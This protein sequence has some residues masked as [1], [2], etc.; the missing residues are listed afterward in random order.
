MI[1]NFNKEKYLGDLFD[2]IFNQTYSNWECIIVDDHSTDNSWEILETYSQ[3]DS[4]IK[5]F[6]RPKFRKKG[7]S[8]ARNYAI[9]LAK[10]EYVALL[11][12]DDTWGPNRLKLAI[13]FLSSQNIAAIFSGAI[14][15]RQNSTEKLSS[16]DINNAESIFD[17]I[18]SDDVFCP[19]PSLILQNTLARNVMFDEGLKRHEDFDFFIRVHAISPWKYFE[20]YDVRINWT[21]ED[22]KVINFKECIPFYEKHWQKSR[23]DKI[24]HKYIIRITSSS[25]RGNYKYN[26]AYYFKKVLENEGY[27]FSFKQYILFYM[28]FLF[29]LFSK[30]KWFFL[31]FFSTSE[32]S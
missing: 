10:G 9:E 16:R 7:V 25:V 26:L 18:F 22:L 3:K 15:L 17:F 13:E 8:T 19:T 27:K 29:L 14:V 4:R 30:S 6:K 11:D 2:S 32:I 31:K 23:N 20:N 24:R 28:P 21:R 12:S 5:I 1:P